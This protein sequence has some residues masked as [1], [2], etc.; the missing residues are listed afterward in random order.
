MFA[1]RSQLLFGIGGDDKYW[2]RDQGD[3]FPVVLKSLVLSQEG[4]ILLFIETSIGAVSAVGF[5]IVG[6]SNVRLHGYGGERTSVF[7]WS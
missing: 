3:H 2:L 1:L 4:I 7:S 5:A 6:L